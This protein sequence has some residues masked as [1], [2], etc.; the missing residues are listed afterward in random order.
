LRAIISH[1]FLLLLCNL[2]L[3]C[4]L[5][6]AAAHGD[7]TSSAFRQKLYLSPK[8]S[9]A[10]RCTARAPCLS[11]SRAY[12]VAKPG[13]IVE[14]TAG[15][16]GP[17]QIL[18]DP[19][20][21]SAADV[22]FR[23][24]R[25]ASVFVARVNLGAWYPPGAEGASHITIQNMAVN[26]LS[27][28]RASDITWQN[29]DARSF[30]MNAVRDVRV[31]GGDYGPC[32][33][34][35]DNPFT[36]CQNSKIDLAPTGRENRN[37]TIDDVV[38][39]DYRKGAAGDHWECLIIFSGTG[40]TL[41]NSRFVNCEYFDVFFE[42]WRS[43][44]TD[45]PLSD[46]VIE[47]NWFDTPWNGAGM[48]NRSTGVAFSL[49]TAGISNV[50]VRFNS[51]HEST[52]LSPNT[53]GS[54]ANIV[55]FRVIGNLFGRNDGCLANV[56]YASNVRMSG[57]FCG[58]K[59]V[60]VPWG[61]TLRQGALQPVSRVAGVVRSIFT[62]IARGTRAAT[63]AR[64][65]NTQRVLSPDASGWNATS[66]RHIVLSQTYLGRQW[67]SQGTHPALVTKRLAGKARAKLAR[68]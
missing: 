32:T 58:P 3:V 54:G 50:L 12:Q 33:S 31:K 5:A 2:G 48:K 39:H 57:R 18:A 24:A 49:Q 16:Y 40:I 41:R 11:F 35:V 23:P 61:Y 38:F 52:G 6:D 46:I 53:E 47:N 28:Y 27:A 17:Q 59:E 42:D 21:T 30:Y 37:I 9:D 34:T 14:V 22:V 10:A 19:T 65:L 25:G 29:I 1:C 4:S 56:S 8:G 26:L 62:R 44:P 13:Q 7:Q 36:T 67:G 60:R 43:N 45:R 66:I 68:D 15:R 64:S 55:R 63:V 51:F 20:K